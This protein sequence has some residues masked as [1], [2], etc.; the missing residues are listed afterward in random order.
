MTTLTL[1]TMGTGELDTTSDTTSETDQPQPTAAWEDDGG[2]DDDNW[3]N[4]NPHCTVLHTRRMRLYDPAHRFAGMCGATARA[5]TNGCEPLTLEDDAVAV[6]GARFVTAAEVQ[7]GLGAACSLNKRRRWEALEQLGLD[8]TH[9]AAV[10]RH[11]RGVAPRAP[12]CPAHARTTGRGHA[13]A[14][15]PV[16]RAATPA[17]PRG[18]GGQDLRLR[19][20]PAPRRDRHLARGV[21][22]AAGALALG[23]AAAPPAAP[24]RG[25][26]RTAARRQGRQLAARAPRRAN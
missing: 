16:R 3:L 18:C 22:A 15:R 7:Y 23:Q 12:Q 1:R 19:A 24:V 21:G 4:P 20:R 8:A 17:A 6:D 5:D 9:T 2:W 10:V 13:R 14:H 25:A 26:E 11:G